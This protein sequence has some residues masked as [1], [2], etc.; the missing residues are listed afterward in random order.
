MTP[1]RNQIRL[2]PRLLLL[3]LLTT[4]SSGCTSDEECD[5][6]S[7]TL[8]YISEVEGQDPS[9]DYDN[10]KKRVDNALV[11]IYDEDGQLQRT[12]KLTRKEIENK[13][14]IKIDTDGCRHPQVVVWGNLNGSEDLS[15]INPGVPIASTRVSMQQEEGFALS[16]DILY[17]GYKK[18]TDESL[19]KIEI[20][21][22][23][24]SVYITV[25]G[26]DQKQIYNDSY[27]FIIESEYNSYDFYGNPQQG[28]AVLKVDA[29]TEFYQRE[30]VLVHPSVNLIGYPT[31]SDKSQ[32]M[33]VK[34]YKRKPEGDVL[35][36]SADKDSEGNNIMAHAGDNTNILLD[37]IDNK[38]NVYY[39]LTPWENIY[40]WAW[41]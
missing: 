19:Q 24:G 2:L 37:F 7:T 18:L 16:T 23:V 6:P 8:I 40:Q 31:N 12:V 38:L 14:P 22:W 1:S 34:L 33:T 21:T 25:C 5:S 10:D 27:Y 17:Y 26:I 11:L 32:S 4:I 20:T 30:P 39:K 13:A 41:W 28:K 35:I 3:M 29:R 9:F 15:V 36:A